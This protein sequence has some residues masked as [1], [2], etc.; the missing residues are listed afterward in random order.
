VGGEVQKPEFRA[1]DP[2]PPSWESRPPAAEALTVARVQTARTLGPNNATAT[3]A[4]VRRSPGQLSRVGQQ[5]FTGSLRPG[6]HSCSVASG[7]AGAV[8]MACNP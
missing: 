3:T 8:V 2:T 6:R 5:V 4:L 1:V 7:P